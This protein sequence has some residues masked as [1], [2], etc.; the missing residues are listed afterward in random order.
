VLR[1][2]ERSSG[3]PTVL[4]LMF[5]TLELLQAGMLLLFFNMDVGS[6]CAM[7]LALLLQNRCIGV[8][9]TILVLQAAAHRWSW[10]Y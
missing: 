3:S 2:R 5:I 9:V 1:Q 7:V 8:C 6:T 10:G 4:Q